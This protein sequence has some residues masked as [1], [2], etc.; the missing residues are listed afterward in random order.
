M[1]F[2]VFQ[3]LILLFSVVVHEVSHGFIAEK[4]GDPTAR[5]A[6]R[7]TLNPLKHLDFFGSI[8][9]PFFLFITHSPIVFGWAKPVPYNPLLLVKDFRYGPLKVALAGPV[10]NLLIAIFFGLFLRFSHL[11]IPETM[12]VLFSFIVFINILLAVFNL[13]P[14]PPLDGSKI[15]TIILPRKYAWDFERFGFLG[16][17][18]VLLFV[19]FFSNVIFDITAFIFNFIV[20]LP[21]ASFL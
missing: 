8:F 4:L 6:G 1:E 16:I 17:F 14:L 10:A 18:I 20:G 15:F 9:L 5:F 19:F 12:A 3:L 13:L 11:F 21:I 2:I 7:L